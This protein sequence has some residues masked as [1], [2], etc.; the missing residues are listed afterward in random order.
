MPVSPLAGHPLPPG[1]TVDIPRLVTDFF[2]LH[3]DSD[4]PAQQVSFGTSGHRG[5]ASSASFNED[6][7]LAVTEAICRLRKNRNIDGPLFVGCDTHALSRPAFAAAL[8]VLAAHQ[9]TTVISEGDE[10]TP[11]PAISHAILTA[12]RPSSGAPPRGLAD[13]IVITPSHNPPEDGGF[14]YNP[15]SGGP[16]D[17][18]LTR[19]IETLANKLIADKLSG[20]RRIPFAQALRAPTV[21]RRDFLSAYIA[22]LQNVIDMEAIAR[23]GVRIGIDPLGGAS[24]HYWGRLAEKYGLALTVV[25]ETVDPTFAFMPV[26][27]DGKIRMDPSSPYAMAGLL[28]MASRYDIAAACDTDSD[29]H[30]IVSPSAGLMNPNH[31]LAVL[32]SYLFSHRPG[33]PKGAGVGKTLVSSR[34]IDRVADFLGRRLVEVPVGFKWFVDGLLDGSLGFGGEESAGASFLRRDGTV[35]TTDK[36]GIVPA[37]AA[38]EMTAVTGIEPGRAYQE[39]EERFG[40]FFYKRIDAVAN[41]ALKKAVGALTPEALSIDSVAGDRVLRVLTAAPGNGAPIGGLKVETEGGWFAVRP[42]GTEE[43]VKVYAESGKS[44]AHLEEILAEAQGIMEEVAKK[45]R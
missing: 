43:I 9:V 42:S 8:E 25:R 5:S 31:Y 33:W 37:L 20:V 38:A 11:T 2:A 12:N 28:K 1:Q 19:E 32:V 40:A 10:P 45:A 22:D 35:W 21:S 27:H 13:G 34:M 4:N 24:V 3:P 6:H 41:S 30:G 23:S 15:P 44:P 36:D 18:A 17:P 7:I 29:R 14:K 26:D 39:L 16:A